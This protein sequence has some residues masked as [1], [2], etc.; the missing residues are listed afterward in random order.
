[1]MGVA[2]QIVGYTFYSWA[3]ILA[4]LLIKEQPEKGKNEDMLEEV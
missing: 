4:Y 1:M 2:E 3:F